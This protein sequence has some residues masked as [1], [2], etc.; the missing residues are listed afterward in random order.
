VWKC[1][2]RRAHGSPAAK[3]VEGIVV[4]VHEGALSIRRRNERLT[5]R[6]GVKRDVTTTPEAINRD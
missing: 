3:A 5:K 6:Q 4:L 1:I 2:S